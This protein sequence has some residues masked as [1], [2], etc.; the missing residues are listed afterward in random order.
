MLTDFKFID[1]F[2]GI[3]G[4]HQAMASLGG[5]CVFASDIDKHCQNT[6]FKNYG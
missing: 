6:Y 4:F 1:L 5:K 2:C 3:G